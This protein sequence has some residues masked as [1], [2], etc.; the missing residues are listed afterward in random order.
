MSFASCLSWTITFQGLVQDI[1]SPSII[2]NALFLECFLL[3]GF[4]Q[5]CDLHGYKMY[6]QLCY[7]R[8]YEWELYTPLIDWK[9][10]RLFDIHF[11]LCFHTKNDALCNTELDKVRSVLHLG[12]RRWLSKILLMTGDYELTAPRREVAH[13]LWTFFQ[14]HTEPGSQV[15]LREEQRGEGWAFVPS[16]SLPPQC[17]I[18]SCCF[19]LTSGHY[20]V[21]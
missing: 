17:H 14:P 9:Y 4:P 18:S 10:L 21:R 6:Y 19:S 13:P 2:S 1:T 15:V 12:V 5:T 8:F 20:S 7:V 16:P 3:H 11:C